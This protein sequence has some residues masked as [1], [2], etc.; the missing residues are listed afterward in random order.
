MYKLYVKLDEYLLALC[1]ETYLWV[2]DRTGI[3]VATV[4]FMLYAVVAALQLLLNQGSPW[5]W[6]PLIVFVGL[7]ASTQYRLQDKGPVPFNAMSLAVR[8]LP[9]RFYVNF[10][11]LSLLLAQA[12]SLVIRFD[13]AGFISQVLFVLYGYFQVVLIRDRD[14]KPF[15]EKQEQLSTESAP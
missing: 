3:Y 5:V 9:L 14:K 4:M 11:M 1:Q 2:F 15:F 10:F 8:S 7:S 13:L 6:L 12:F